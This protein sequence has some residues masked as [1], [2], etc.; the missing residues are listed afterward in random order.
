VLTKSCLYPIFV[1]ISRSSLATSG[2]LS[3][4]GSVSSSGFSTSSGTTT[5]GESMES[6]AGVSP[7]QRK[8]GVDGDGGVVRD[9]DGT[10]GTRR[11]T[12]TKFLQWD[13]DGRP[14]HRKGLCDCFAIT[15]RTHLRAPL[16][17]CRRPWGRL[18]RFLGTTVAKQKEGGGG[19]GPDGEVVA[20]G[21]VQK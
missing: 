12:V 10:H 9:V 19:Q 7:A 2:T 15:R 11:V 13:R 16:S 20:T 18:I 1:R 5:G 3:A 14:A 8:R 4:K 6:A 17:H 21:G